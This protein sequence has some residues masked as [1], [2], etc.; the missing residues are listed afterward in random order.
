MKPCTDA[1]IAHVFGTDSEEWKNRDTI[2]MTFNKPMVSTEKD[3]AESGARFAASV[4]SF[5]Q[6]GLPA[7]I[8]LKLTGQFF[9]SVKMDDE[10]IKQAHDNYNPQAK[11]NNVGVQSINTGHFTKPQKAT[12]RSLK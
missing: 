1:L 11:G 4:A 5:C 12:V 9:P 7:D 8:A 2:K 10:L 3:M 6:A